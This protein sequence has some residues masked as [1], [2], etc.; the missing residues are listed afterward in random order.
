MQSRDNSFLIGELDPGGQRHCLGGQAVTW[1]SCPSLVASVVSVLFSHWVGQ[2]A[3]ILELFL[4][5]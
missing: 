5:G 2:D 3:I 4:A 1:S